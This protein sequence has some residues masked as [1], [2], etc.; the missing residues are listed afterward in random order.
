MLAPCK[1]YMTLR[2]FATASLSV[3]VRDFPGI[4]ESLVRYYVREVCIAIKNHRA[5]FISLP[6]NSVDTKR[7]VDGF[8]YRN[9]F[10]RVMGVVSCFRIKI[11][12]PSKQKNIFIKLQTIYAGINTIM[13]YSDSTLI[14]YYF[15]RSRQCSQI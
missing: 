6:K 14:L 13:L 1:L 8:F 9:Q 10:P 12:P 2:Y 5:K 7:V 3:T 15:C 4:S 11:K